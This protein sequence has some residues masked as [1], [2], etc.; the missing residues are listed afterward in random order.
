MRT[1]RESKDHSMRILALETS[2][3]S[4]SLAIGE[5][6]DK[7]G[8]S[9]SQDDT[10]VSQDSTSISQSGTIKSN[11][12]TNLKIVA[13]LSLPANERS[14]RTL[15]PAIDTA[16]H[17]S[18]WSADS[19]DV[20]G[21]SIGPGSFT[22]LRVGL[23]TARMIAWAVHAKLVAIDTRDAIAQ[24]FFDHAHTEPQHGDQSL[25]VWIDA[26]RGQVVTATYQLEFHSSQPIEWKRITSEDNPIAIPSA[27]ANLPTTRETWLAGTILNRPSVLAKLPESLKRYVVAPPLSSPN[28]LG[29]LTLSVIRAAAGDFNDLRQ[30]TPF[31]SRPSAATERLLAAGADSPTAR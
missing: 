14:A 3:T 15:A 8:T 21:I 11:G 19:L 16:L 24:Q 22:G 13:S 20:I 29:V 12:S 9:I 17:Q 6:S 27:L 31:Y 2:E 23:A 25:T 18:G 1:T 7:L 10:T 26:Q 4:G 30:L 5:I 28:A